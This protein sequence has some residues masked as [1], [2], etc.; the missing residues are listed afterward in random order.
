MDGKTLISINEARQLLP[1][2]RSHT[3]VWRWMRK[4]VKTR[5]GVTVKLA[6]VRYGGELFTTAEDLTR[7]GE[8]LARADAAHFDLEPPPAP[9]RTS[10]RSEGRRQREIAGARKR[11]KDAGIA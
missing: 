7:F 11:L 5:S 4:G 3:A 6:H 8:E 2:P 10:D 1:T 9:G